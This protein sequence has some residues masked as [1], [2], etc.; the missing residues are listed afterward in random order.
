MAE[1]EKLN[2]EARG[3]V[4]AERAWATMQLGRPER[5]REDADQAVKLAPN[6]FRT[7]LVQGL[8]LAESGETLEAREPFAKAQE[9]AAKEESPDV[10]IEI[11]AFYLRRR[12]YNEA[13]DQA[14]QAVRL[15]P[16]SMEALA[17]RATVHEF[18]LNDQAAQR[19]AENARVRSEKRHWK[20]RA[21]ALMVLAR[22][23]AASNDTD[24][25][26]RRAQEASE[27]WPDSSECRLLCGY[28]LL[29]NAGTER[30]RL[31]KAEVLAKEVI[32][33]A[34]NLT[35][36]KRLLG[37]INEA[38]N[39]NAGKAAQ[40]LKEVLRILK[41]DARILTVL[42]E[43]AISEGRLDDVKKRRERAIEVERDVESPEGDFFARASAILGAEISP[44]AAEDP[45]KLGLLTKRARTTLE[46]ALFFNPTNVH[47]LTLLG[48]LAIERSDFKEA[49]IY[50]EKAIKLNPLYAPAHM[51]LAEL[52]SGVGG[53]TSDI[54]SGQV[55]SSI[56]AAKEQLVSDADNVPALIRA[57]A[58]AD[59]RPS[60]RPPGEKE[61]RGLI[62]VYQ[63]LLT[64]DPGNSRYIIRQRKL[65]QALAQIKEVPETE[66]GPAIESLKKLE[67]ETRAN[68]LRTYETLKPILEGLRAGE[69]ST[70]NQQ[71]PLVQ[72]SP[73]LPAAWEALFW[74]ACSE[75]QSNA[76]IA[77]L[78]RLSI[79]S[80]NRG[81]LYPK[82]LTLLRKNPIKDPEQTLAETL[83]LF[84]ERINMTPD[85]LTSTLTRALIFSSCA[86]RNTQDAALVEKAE[87]A[88]RLA[89]IEQPSLSV[90]HGLLGTLM[91]ATNRKEDG[92]K[93]VLLAYELTARGP[94]L[95]LELAR[96]YN[97]LKDYDM[98]L[99][100]LRQA[101]SQLSKPALEFGDEFK[102]LKDKAP[103][104]WKEFKLP[105]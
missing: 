55:K 103:A 24:N 18:M 78:V 92:L 82:L 58:E 95:S 97:E 49:T 70:T 64:M 19:D 40:K 38:S 26:L 7:W 28:L 74:G 34:T 69:A 86:L 60:N 57:E 75:Q 61:I 85:R 83:K 94:Y 50:L 35:G 30:A 44:E 15:A 48:E 10:L 21:T 90:A 45:I 22:L 53:A 20:A 67:E 13:L 3:R 101:A 6:H 5:A 9:L 4:L 27:A 1:K 25:A 99:R 73:R 29:N 80:P 76:A 12:L 39:D 37:L 87:A 93:N 81:D 105:E 71:W 62:T 32:K 100:L 16:R 43:L 79:L 47:A 46:K 63:K 31:E 54:R 51:A 14:E 84:S 11:C 72:Q 96:I 2:D 59:L 88:L 104:L 65:Y 41:T 68:R 98:T 66:V 52:K 36:G 33:K 89:I 102:A 77:A 56:K 42:G 23:L 8:V 91:L 17:A